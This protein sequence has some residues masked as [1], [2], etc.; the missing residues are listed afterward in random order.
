MPEF[1]NYVDI[2]PSDYVWECSKSEIKE[3]I[4]VLNEKGYIS[5]SSGV[6][7]EDNLMDLEYKN[8][9]DK[10]YSKRVYLTLE[11]EEIIKK[12]ANRL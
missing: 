3:L 2:D 12:I 7:G 9:L 11:E 5:T 6:I 10:L 8:A 1:R 4:E